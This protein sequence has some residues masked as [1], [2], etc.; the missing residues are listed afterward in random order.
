MGGVYLPATGE[1][2]VTFFA[3]RVYRHTGGE[4]ALYL[5]II[6]IEGGQ[7]CFAVP[8]MEETSCPHSKMP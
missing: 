7:V 8:S 1:T 4:D 3:V 6:R 5:P 2:N